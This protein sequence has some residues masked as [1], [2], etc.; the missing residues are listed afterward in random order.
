MP[1][2]TLRHDHA[3]TAR[4]DSSLT[5]IG[6]MVYSTVKII[7]AAVLAVVLI[8]AILVDND[9]EVWAVPLLGLLVG[10]VLGNANVSENAPIISTNEGA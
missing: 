10:Y 5:S 3:M 4:S 6:G 1:N 9:A 8:V 7:V 2:R